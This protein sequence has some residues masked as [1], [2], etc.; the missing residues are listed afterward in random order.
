MNDLSVRSVMHEGVI[1]CA[2]DASLEEVA[3]LMREERISALVVVEGGVAVGVI[4]Q[5]DL[6]NA[7]YVQP[8]LRYWRGMVARHL[9]NSPV[10]SVRPDTPV[11]EALALLRE[12]RI[13]RVV[14]TEPGEGGER[15][16]GILSLTDIARVLDDRPA[17]AAPGRE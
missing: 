15:P 13:H 12:R 9:M 10:I 6:V 17:I 2:P 8:Y 4:S 5:T 16:I 11:A 7:A 14:V 1:S 3:R